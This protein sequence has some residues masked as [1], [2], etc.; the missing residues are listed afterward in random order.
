MTDDIVTRLQ[1][2]VKTDG[3]RYLKDGAMLLAS[4]EIERLR[5]ELAAWQGTVRAHEYLAAKTA[6]EI[7]QLQALTNKQVADDPD[8]IV[9]ELRDWQYI[10]D[11]VQG[12]AAV[13]M[14]SGAVFGDAAAEIERLRAA[15]DA[16]AESLSCIIDGIG[17][18]TEEDVVL[19]AWNEARRDQ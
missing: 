2:L 14:L 18:A 11:G 4:A 10:I 19:A 15:G 7:E 17:V 9:Q 8:D 13:M 16:L 5:D 12:Q 1:Y 6:D 3:N